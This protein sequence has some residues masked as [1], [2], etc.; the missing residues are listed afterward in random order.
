LPHLVIVNIQ[1]MKL[2][3]VLLILGLFLIVVGVILIVVQLVQ[4]MKMRQQP[5]SRKVTLSATGL[6]VQTDYSGIILVC[7]G[8]VLAMIGVTVSN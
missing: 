2:S 1:A 7:V 8:A 6:S 5:R 3:E 4:A